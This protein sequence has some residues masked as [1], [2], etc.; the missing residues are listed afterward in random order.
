MALIINYSIKTREGFSTDQSLAFVDLHF[1]Q[2][3][4]VQLHLYRTKQD[5]ID[6]AN[7]FQQMDIPT[8]WDLSGVLTRDLMWGL[9]NAP[10]LITK[11]HAELKKEIEK[12][13]GKNTVQVIQDPYS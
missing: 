13:T 8:Q 2:S 10:Q 5:F 4:Y 9:N 3:P 11:I 12:I 1:T 6:A 7:E